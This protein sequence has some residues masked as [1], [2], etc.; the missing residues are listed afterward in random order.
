M[1]VEKRNIRKEFVGYR[2][3]DETY[4]EIKKKA[5]A[6]VLTLAFCGVSRLL[7]NKMNLLMKGWASR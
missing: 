1:A 3:I 2:G 7:S 6:F 4:G 5:I